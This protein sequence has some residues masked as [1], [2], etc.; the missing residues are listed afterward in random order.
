MNNGFFAAK[1]AFGLTRGMARAA[2]VDLTE[3]VVEGWLTR[4]ELAQLVDRCLVCDSGCDC[5]AWLGRIRE[6]E[7]VP[8]FCE[9]KQAIEAL[10]GEH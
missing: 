5:L 6:T 10:R 1:G 9:N 3:A 4:T 8:G 7:K 2:G